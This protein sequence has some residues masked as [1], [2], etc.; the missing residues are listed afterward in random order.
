[1]KKKEESL[2]IGYFGKF[3][4]GEEFEVYVKFIYMEKSGGV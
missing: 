4:V 1:M 3:Y 2:G